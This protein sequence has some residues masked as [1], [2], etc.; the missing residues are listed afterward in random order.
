MYCTFANLIILLF[1]EEQKSY[2]FRK[3]KKNR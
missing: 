3:R 1:T 2:V